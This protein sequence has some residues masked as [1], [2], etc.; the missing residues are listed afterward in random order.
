MSIRD[1]SRFHLSRLHIEPLYTSETGYQLDSES[2]PTSC[3]EDY[4]SAI[5]NLLSSGKTTLYNIT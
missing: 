4:C 2:I 3:H 1:G 5:E